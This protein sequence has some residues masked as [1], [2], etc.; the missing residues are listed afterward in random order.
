MEKGKNRQATFS[1]YFFSHFL[2][3]LFEPGSW[4]SGL[5]YCIFPMRVGLKRFF[6]CGSE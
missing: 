3:L 5:V 1:H 6:A 4:G 2:G